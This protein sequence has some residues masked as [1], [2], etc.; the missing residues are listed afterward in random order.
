MA[1]RDVNILGAGLCGSLLSIMIARHGY[2]VTI[3]EM[4]PDPRSSQQAAGRSINL[5]LSA[6]GIRGLKHAGVFA[7]VEPLLM[8]MRGRMIHETDGR[9]ELLAYGL[10]E[11]ELIYSVSRAE[12]N[13]I[14]IE[15]AVDGFGVRILFEHAVDAF[16][17]AAGEVV[18]KSA[19]E[20][21][22]LPARAL[23]AADGA[24]SVIR[25]GYEHDSRIAPTESLLPHSYKE[26]TIPPTPDGGFEME[27]DALHIWP[28]SDFMLIALPNPG[29]DFTLTLFMPNEGDSSFAALD[30]KPKVAA[31]FDEHF[32]DVV[33]LIPNL[34]NSYLTNPVGILGTV[35]CRHWHDEDKVLLI[36]DAAHAIVPFHGQGMNL[37]FEDCVLFDE[38]LARGE[39]NWAELYAEFEALQLVNAN[40]IADMALD[41]YV[42][43]RDTVRDP[44]FA[45]RKEL[46]FELERRMPDRFI[47]QYSMVMFHDEIPYA[48]AQRR[49]R[50][51]AD[52]LAE[53]IR[54]VESLADI[55]L[56]R[57]VRLARE[58]LAPL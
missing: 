23:I 12:L 14:L 50:I 21:Y 4:R 16:D 2:P 47:P 18:M 1:K 3:R 15:K 54:E 58:R 33:P 40:A 43:M 28:R 55:D 6:R 36:G 41:N 24:G 35:R 22:S 7:D 9:K 5:A 46:S 13:R 29:G 26:L 39:P 34:V 49:G 56:E 27:Q 11:N 17:P 45:L 57:A 25:R 19:G 38:L 51:Q 10:R 31:F 44:K 32:S 48:V 37:A 53:L 30:S 20:R 8:P 52:L 42:E